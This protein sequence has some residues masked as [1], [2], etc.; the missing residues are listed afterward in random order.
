[1]PRDRERVPQAGGFLQW[2]FAGWPVTGQW[3]SRSNWQDQANTLNSDSIELCLP[4]RPHP[5]NSTTYQIAPPAGR[6]V[7]K[8]TGPWETSAFELGQE[9][10]QNNTPIETSLPSEIT[11]ILTQSSIKQTETLCPFLLNW[12]LRINGCPRTVPLTHKVLSIHPSHL[13]FCI[14]TA[15]PLHSLYHC[16]KIN[17]S[18]K[19]KKEK[20]ETNQ[21]KRRYLLIGKGKK[22]KKI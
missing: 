17:F 16:H 3:I 9:Y 20:K 22:T 10:W 5:R 19:R 8:H 6:H 4:T 21:Q 1:M 11:S 13:S 2:E 14:Q 15:A 7:L 12:S 18:Q